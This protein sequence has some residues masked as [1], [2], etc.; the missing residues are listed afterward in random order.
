MP[1]RL[2]DDESPS[3]GLRRIARAELGLAI[4]TLRSPT[5][6]AVRIH[7]ARK[8]L[9]KLRAL[10]RLVREHTGKPFFR[11][12]NRR[13]RDL[14]RRLAPMRDAEVARLTLAQLRRAANTVPARRALSRLSD[15]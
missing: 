3:D 15:H 10:L 14:G 11:A 1:F 5:R 6:E 7:S 12:R 8:H 2:R 13:L 9:K 4:R